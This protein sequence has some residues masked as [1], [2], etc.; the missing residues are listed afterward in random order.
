MKKIINTPETLVMEMCSGMAMTHPD[1][2]FIPEYKIMKRKE[3]NNDKVI[4]ISG[5]GSGHEPAHAGYVGKG[6][7]DAAVCGE[8]FASPS[9]IQVYQAI[10][11]TAGSKGTLLII[12]NYSGDIMNFKNAATLAEDVDVEYVIVN[13]DIA[14]ND[15]SYTV[16]RR[17]VA[18]TVLVHKIAGAAAEIGCS[19]KEVKAIAQHTVNSVRSIGMALTSCTVPAKGKPTFEIAD[20]QIEFG[21]GIHGESG[22]GRRSIMTAD[23]IAE[24]MID[25]LIKDLGIIA[26]DEITLLV[27]GFGGI[28]LHELYVLCNCARR[29]LEERN[30]RVYRTFVGDYMTSIDMQGTSISILK[31]D[32]L[33]KVLLSA[34]CDTPGLQVKGE[35]SPIPYVDL[36]KLKKA[37]EISEYGNMITM[38][39][40]DISSYSITKN[41]VYGLVDRMGTFII[42]NEVAFC[43]LDSYAGDGDFGMSVAKGFRRLKAEWEN[44][45]LEGQKGIGEFLEAC[46]FVIM[47]HCG[48]ASGPIWG[49]AFLR[50]GRSCKGRDELSVDEFSKL[51][52]AAVDGIQKTG[53]Q[54]FGRGAVVGDKTLIDALIP[55]ANSWKE[56]VK[57][58]RTMAEA[59]CMG[60]QEAVA[61]AEST[62]QIVA[63]MG[64]AGTVGKRSLGYPDA[65][66]FALGKIFTYLSEWIVENY[67]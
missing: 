11:A 31:M 39:P 54:S 36:S 6:M 60:A 50:A 16:G 32:D 59:F 25:A 65:G 2:E 22:I 20:N 9:Q 42:E 14:V 10:K 46:A 37:A 17:G 49:S 19:L 55:C 47:E 41:G 33:L 8:M 66:A 44:V 12:K 45:I 23:Q 4:L 18:G 29:E 34:E 62:K 53:E 27:N 13:D 51:I 58:N 61:G 26:E 7:L 63:R 24:E 64:R 52:Q 21:V 3:I 30:I 40:G 5:G 56:S 35:I 57:R 28:P 67:K 38:N 43:E 15:S 1:L 48:G